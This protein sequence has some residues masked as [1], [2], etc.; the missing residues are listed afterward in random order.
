VIS[1][2]YAVTDQEVIIG[3]NIPLTGPYA[4]KGKDQLQAYKLA[5]E[6]VN[7]QEVLSE[8]KFAT[9]MPTVKVTRK[10]RLKM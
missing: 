9:F 4:L 8:R 2:S 5:Q 10:F 6:E 1:P 7:A 3:L